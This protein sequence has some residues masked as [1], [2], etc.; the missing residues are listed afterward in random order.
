M[1]ASIEQEM[2]VPS[3]SNSTS[4]TMKCLSPFFGSTA[5]HLLLSNFFGLILFNAALFTI[6]KQLLRCERH[7]STAF[8]HSD[9][10]F[11]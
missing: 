7:A 4:V 3:S 8:V 1:M 10:Y 9:V 11:Q 2:T 6:I 5:V